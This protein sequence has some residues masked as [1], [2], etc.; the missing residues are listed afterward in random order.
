MSID[1]VIAF[2]GLVSLITGIYLWLGLPASLIMLGIIMIYIGARLQP[3]RGNEP[4]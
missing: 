3:R 2:L 1:D 4:D